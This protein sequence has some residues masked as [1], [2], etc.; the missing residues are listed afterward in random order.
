MK[1][2]ETNHYS[3]PVSHIIHNDVI[4]VERTHLGNR[5]FKCRCCGKQ[6]TESL[7]S[8]QILPNEVEKNLD[9]Y[10]RNYQSCKNLK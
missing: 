9:K 8:A 7:N 5:E 3:T 4:E 1:A 6:W 2:I 10:Y